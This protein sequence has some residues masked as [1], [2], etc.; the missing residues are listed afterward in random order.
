VTST[1]RRHNPLIDEWVL[2]SPGRTKRPWLGQ[3]EDVVVDAPVRYDPECYLCPSNT[4]LTGDVNPPYEGTFVFANDFAALR[5]DTPPERYDDGL[6]RSEAEDGTCRVICYSPRHD[7]RMALMEPAEIATVVD[8]W[9]DQAAELGARYRW[10]QIFEN[11]GEAMGASNPHPH[12]QIW[13]GSALPTIPAREDANQRRYFDE[14]GSS[15]L[16]D[17]VSRDGDGERIV[18]DGGEWVALVPYWATW[19]FETLVVPRTPTARITDIDDSS[20]A[21]LARVLSELLIRYDNLFEHPFP[22]SMGW[23][24]APHDATATDHWQLHAHFY[25]P[26]LRSA[27]VRKFMVG[28]EL[29]AEPQRDL[30]PEEAAARLR[31]VSPVH[32]T[33][34][35]RA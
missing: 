18:V 1:H 14:H 9:R 34:R 23:H 29:L 32:Y 31:A 7:L 2:V 27:T 10:V 21:S 22:Y 25:P 19:P 11:N 8:L 16:V 28:Y 35:A 4:R 24:G 15:M 3:T 33:R 17:Y 20:R 5:P 26:L 6:L 12:G 13:A 30:S